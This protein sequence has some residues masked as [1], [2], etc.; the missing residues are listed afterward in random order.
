M[1][2]LWFGLS[3]AALACAASA[4]VIV[5]EDGV[6]ATITPLEDTFENSVDPTND[7]GVVY[8][9]L[10]FEGNVQTP[11]GTLLRDD[12]VS[13]ISSPSTLAVFRFVGGVGTV[14]H[15]AFFDL[16]DTN[17]NLVD[18]FG[19]RLPTAG[20]T[21]IWTITL[22]DP[23]SVSVPAA[24]FVDMRGDTGANNPDGLPS[25]IGWRFKDV[26]PAIGSSQGNVHR[27]VMDVIPEPAS[28]LLLGLGAVALGRRR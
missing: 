18:S 12:Y 10:A 14:N 26:Q 21:T 5:F 1:K 7:V 28:L 17:S 6:N 4:E 16:R 20:F 3:V 11:T 9:S 15:V 19:V 8:D 2:R 22:N 23:T 24:G 13:T 27:M 25:T